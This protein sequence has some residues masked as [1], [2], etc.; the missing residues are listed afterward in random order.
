MVASEIVI[1]FAPVRSR[2]DSPIYVRVIWKAR[3]EIATL[4]YVGSTPITHSKL[5]YA[6][7]GQSV[8]SISS[9]GI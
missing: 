1:L 5:L 4:D 6:H 9:N 7:I 3:N 2:L 8:E